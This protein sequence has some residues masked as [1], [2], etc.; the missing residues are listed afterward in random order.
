M[1]GRI[2]AVVP[3]AGVGRRM[4]AGLPK[5]YLPL[6]GRAV[7]EHTLDRLRAHPRICAVVVALAEHDEHFARLPVAASVCIARGGAQRADSVLGA[8]DVIAGEAGP[9]DWAL[10]HDAVRPCLHPAD[11]DRLIAEALAHGEGALLAAPVRDTM[12]LVAEGRVQRSVPRDGLWHA[13]TPQMFPLDALRAALLA[14]RHAGEPITDE[15]QAMERAGRAPRV[16]Q[17]RADNIKIT[18]TEDLQLAAFYLSR[19]ECSQ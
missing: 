14:A 4:G 16:V 8:L 10:V 19:M 13:L 1:S 17:G 18:R 2:W 5:Q 11:L 15:A 6:A 9:G 7:I 12:K 3:A